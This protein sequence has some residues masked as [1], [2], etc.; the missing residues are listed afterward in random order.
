MF[1]TSLL[2]YIALTHSVFSW[3]NDS[4]ISKEF[5]GFRI[6]RWAL[7]LLG[8]IWVVYAQIIV[9]FWLM[10]DRIL[11]PLDELSPSFGLFLLSSL[12]GPFALFFG[13]LGLEGE[14]PCRTTWKKS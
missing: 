4:S 10:P 13:L 9:L 11:V 7:I 2:L 5:R 14:A 12:L 1:A 8:C 3:A 6:C